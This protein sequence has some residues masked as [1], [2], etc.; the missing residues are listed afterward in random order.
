[1]NTIERTSPATPTT[2]IDAPTPGAQVVPLHVAWRVIGAFALA[3]VLSVVALWVDTGSSPLAE[4]AS[5]PA[6]A[7]VCL[8]AL[9]LVAFGYPAAVVRAVR[10]DEGADVTGAVFFAEFTGLG[11]ATVTVLAWA[12][13]ILGVLPTLLLGAAGV[14]LLT[15]AIAAAVEQT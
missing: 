6:A 15:P 8:A 9:L 2:P 5:D 7:L 10:R 13:G 14:V 3:T 12:L 4:V 1:M 11:V